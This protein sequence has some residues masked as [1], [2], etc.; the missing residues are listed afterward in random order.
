[1]HVLLLCVVTALYGE[2]HVTMKSCREINASYELVM[3]N[4]SNVL[5]SLLEFVASKFCFSLIYWYGH[6]SIPRLSQ[7]Q[8]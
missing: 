4:I 8:S 1:M 7:D 5:P 6:N 3:P 2:T